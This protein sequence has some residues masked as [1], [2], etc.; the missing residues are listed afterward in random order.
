[1]NDRP[2][3]PRSHTLKLEIDG[4]VTFWLVI[5]LYGRFSHHWEIATKLGCVS[6]ESDS[7][8]LSLLVCVFWNLHLSFHPFP[9]DD[10]TS[11]SVPWLGPL[12]ISLLER[13]AAFR[14]C[15][16]GGKRINHSHVLHTCSTHIIYGP[17]SG[18]LRAGFDMDFG[19]VQEGTRLHLN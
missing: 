18:S 7:W 5:A 13:S 3:I 11:T 6:A 8:D 2:R 14:T 16:M 9:A 12:V 10:S 19:L 17:S 4:R 1:M 15:Q